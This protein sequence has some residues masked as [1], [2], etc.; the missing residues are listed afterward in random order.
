MSDHFPWS[1]KVV[2]ITRLLHTCLCLFTGSAH[3]VRAKM[4]SIPNHAKLDDRCMY[5]MFSRESKTPDSTTMGIWGCYCCRKEHGQTDSICQHEQRN[6]SLHWVQC[7]LLLSRETSR[8]VQW[9][10]MTACCNTIEIPW[11]ELKDD[12]RWPFLYIVDSTSPFPT[13]STM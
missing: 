5:I 6:Q 7:L 4:L 9:Y 12:I 1:F 13:D 11:D 3:G 8:D 10:D 2:I